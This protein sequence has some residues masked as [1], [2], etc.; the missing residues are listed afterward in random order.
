MDT[1]P[2]PGGDGR[3]KTVG[4]GGSLFQGGISSHGP[5]LPQRVGG[6]KPHRSLR[7]GE[8]FDQN[9]GRFRSRCADGAQSEDRLH[10]LLNGPLL[11]SFLEQPHGRG[12]CRANL[13]QSQAGPVASLRVFQR[14]CEERHR[15][16]ADLGERI[17][18]RKDH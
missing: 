16:G 14:F 18:R 7:I 1:G 17:D 3:Q 15:R 2:S 10:P 11:G 13:G 12:G 9:V 5:N 6:G 4:I 8:I